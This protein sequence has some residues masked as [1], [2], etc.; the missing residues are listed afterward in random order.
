MLSFKN[1]NST[2]HSKNN[3]IRDNAENHS[4]DNKKNNVIISIVYIYIYYYF[5][6]YF[7]FYSIRRWSSPPYSLL[8]VLHWAW[9]QSPYIN[10][11]LI[12]FFMQSRINPLAGWQPPGTSG[13]VLLSACR[14]TISGYLWF[15]PSAISKQVA[16]IGLTMFIAAYYY[17][18]LFNPWIDALNTKVRNQFKEVIF[19]SGSVTFLAAYHYFQILN[20][21]VD[22][23]MLQISLMMMQWM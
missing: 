15:C 23:N 5:L 16:L 3:D 9:C 4:N 12:A 21:W 18:Q 8:L 17:I 11:P 22:A 1:Y 13:S 20:Y 2:N 6:W 10:I 7:L 19:T 14:M